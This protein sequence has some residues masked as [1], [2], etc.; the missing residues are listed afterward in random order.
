WAYIR[1]HPEIGYSIIGGVD[2]EDRIKKIV[3]LHHEYQDGSGYP[4]GYSAGK[5]P[6]EAAI[7]TVA[8]SLDAI[9]GIRPYRQ[10]YTNEEAIELMGKYQ[11]RYL[12]EA[13]DAARH[14]VKSGEL[15]KA[16]EAT[17]LFI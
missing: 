5:I 10:A 13:F 6:V 7:T 8:D 2:F 15:D 16:S 11:T 12:P 17:S 9:S 1:R 3:L 4:Y 14:L